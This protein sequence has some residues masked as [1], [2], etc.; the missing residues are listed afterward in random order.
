LAFVTV[1]NKNELPAGERIIVEVDDIWVAVFN[2]AGNLYA[3]EDQ[4]THDGES[5]AEGGEL[6]DAEGD[7][8]R[9]ECDRHGA[10]FELKTGKQTF[11]ASVPVQRFPVRLEGDDVQ[12]NVQE[13]L[14]LS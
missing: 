6:L 1:A 9:V 5:L 12:I 7:N 13:P 2:V 14:K 3:V 4:C 10:T 8:P 11:P